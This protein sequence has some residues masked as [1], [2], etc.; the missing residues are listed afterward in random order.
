MNRLAGGRPAPEWGVAREGGAPLA[1]PFDG[2]R[3]LDGRTMII[4]PAPQTYRLA[5]GAKSLVLDLKCSE[6]DV[7]WFLD[8][9]GIGSCPSGS[10]EFRE[11]R[12]RIV[13]VPR[14][15]S[16][17]SASVSFTVVEGE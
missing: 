16:R 3:P 1:R 15:P 7:Y 8:G 10:Y 17:K 13:A 6:T 9:A 2:R 11:G 5:P 14:D 12:H 4:S